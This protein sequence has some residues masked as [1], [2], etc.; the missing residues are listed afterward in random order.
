MT[1]TL[2]RRAATFGIAAWAMAAPAAVALLNAA[3]GAVLAEPEV[4]ARL[5]EI[6]METMGGTPQTIGDRLQAGIAKWSAVVTKAG[7]VRQ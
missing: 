6:G 1:V 3:I 4:K 5:L 7:L 2:D